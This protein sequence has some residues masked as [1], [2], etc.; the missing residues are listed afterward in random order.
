MSGTYA[1]DSLTFSESAILKS[2][3][4]FC[5]GGNR[6][7]GRI[8]AR[9]PSSKG[10]LERRLGVRCSLISTT[11]PMIQLGTNNLPSSL[12]LISAS[13]SVGLMLL[14]LSFR[15]VLSSFWS[16]VASRSTRT[17]SICSRSTS[18]AVTRHKPFE[19]L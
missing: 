14:A 8:R 12:T 10:S 5:F 9:Y 3:N 6:P 15:L 18:P 2:V 19:C 11:T 16:D 7:A 13:V 1:I 17:E 4:G